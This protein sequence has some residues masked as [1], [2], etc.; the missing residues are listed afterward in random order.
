MAVRSYFTGQ[1]AHL[2]PGPNQ[3]ADHCELSDLNN[4]DEGRVPELL[5]EHT[6]ARVRDII[7]QPRPGMAVQ[8]SMAIL[9]IIA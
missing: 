6:Y 8:D 4:E 3:W 9:L 2:D 5:A 7:A 1:Y